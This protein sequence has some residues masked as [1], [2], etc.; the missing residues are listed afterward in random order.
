MTSV[1]DQIAAPSLPAE[2]EVV[3]RSAAS[4]Q[5]VSAPAIAVPVAGER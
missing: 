1:A 5:V 2:T 3:A 4:A